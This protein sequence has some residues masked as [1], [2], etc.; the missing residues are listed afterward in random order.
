[1]RPRL[2]E[3]IHSLSEFKRNT[4]AMVKRMKRTKRPLVLTVNGKAALIVNEPVEY[5]KLLARVEADETAAGIQ[6][7]LDDL[8]A[9]RVTPMRDL[10]E[11]LRADL[12]R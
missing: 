10:L 11:E 2:D 5:E 3:D 9:G 7:G 12:Y 1:M 4:A 8:A 6:R